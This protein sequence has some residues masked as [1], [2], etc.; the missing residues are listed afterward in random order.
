MQKVQENKMKK[1]RKHKEGNRYNKGDP[2]A[3]KITFEI[4]YEFI[5]SFDI[6]CVFLVSDHVM[7]K[8]KERTRMYTPSNI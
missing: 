1:N 4:C 3:I 6:L 7:Y 8:M 2:M 5:E